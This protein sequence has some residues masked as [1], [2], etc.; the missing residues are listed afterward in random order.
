MTEKIRALQEEISRSL[1]AREG[2]SV[3][4]GAIEIGVESP[5]PEEHELVE[6]A[7][8]KRQAEFATARNLARQS[9]R[10]LGLAAGPILRGAKRE[11]IWPEGTLGSMTHAEGCA[12]ACVARRGVVRSL[13]IDVELSDRVGKGLYKKVFTEAELQYLAHKE[14]RHAGLLFSAKEAVYKATFPLVGRFI[15]FQEAE[16]T[17]DEA[18]SRIIFRYVGEHAPNEIMEEAQC[19]YLFSGPYVLCLVTIP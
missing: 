14:E 8:E 11:P 12:V 10:D 19:R 6:T 13:G 7:L 3:K 16:L 2:I 15:G 9:M 4:A 17:V 5:F 18:R 1:P